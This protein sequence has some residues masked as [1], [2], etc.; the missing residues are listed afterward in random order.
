MLSLSGTW[1]GTVKITRSTDGG[2]TRLPLTA[3][4]DSYGSYSAN[5]CEPVWEEGESAA[6]LYLDVTMATGALTYRMGQ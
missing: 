6:Q 3:M 1:T 4:G 2:A 5:I